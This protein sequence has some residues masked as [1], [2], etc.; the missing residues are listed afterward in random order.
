MTMWEC[1]VVARP[2]GQ[3]A[4]GILL[5]WI[6]I[7]GIGSSPLRGQE[8]A[9][10]ALSRV[11]AATVLVRASGARSQKSGVGFL[12]TVKDKVGAIFTS[13]DV[14]CDELAEGLKLECVFH[15]GTDEEQVVKA[16]LAGM[17][18][19]DEWAVLTVS[20][21]ALP[22][23][24]DRDIEDSPH[25]TDS[26]FVLGFPSEAEPVKRRPAPALI[27]MP[28]TITHLQRDPDG[29]LELVQIEGG[30]HRSNA[31]APVVTASGA[32]VGGLVSKLRITPH[33]S[34]ISAVRLAR[35]LEIGV[36]SVAGNL[37][38]AERS[39]WSFKFRVRTIDPFSDVR[40]FT[41]LT[42]PVPPE[43]A[44]TVPMY[45]PAI[46]F[47][48]GPVLADMREH[49]LLKLPSGEF[50]GTVSWT[51]AAETPEYWVQFRWKLADESVHYSGSTRFKAGHWKFFA[52]ILTPAGLDGNDEIV[53]ESAI[54]FESPLTMAV[55]GGSGRYLVAQSQTPPQVH[56]ID[57]QLR[58]RVKTID[59]TADAL[60]AAGFDGFVVIT[61]SD[62]GAQRWSFA[63]AK[64]SEPKPIRVP[65]RI[66][67]VA[68]GHASRGP[69]LVFSAEGIDARNR[70]Y[71][72]LVDWPNWKAVVMNGPPNR[73]G[74]SAPRMRRADEQL[75]ILAAANGSTFGV[76]S[77]T[78][79]AGRVEMIFPDRG[80]QASN[81]I[82]SFGY[83]APTA[84]GARVCTSRGVF[85]TDLAQ[86]QT[87]LPSLPSTSSD[88]YLSLDDHGL[89]V[90]RVSDGQDVRVLVRNDSLFAEKGIRA[91]LLPMERRFFLVPQVNLLAI[92]SPA[93]NRLI[94]APLPLGGAG[95]SKRPAVAI[96][97]KDRDSVPER[98]KEKGKG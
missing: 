6:A 2:A 56:V 33:L 7:G 4:L 59:V 72:S 81:G 97:P 12:F 54:T 98:P 73:P 22:A 46:G 30:I 24:L 67:A 77:L 25:E 79:P 84:D 85:Q 63:G 48:K 50:A 51:I 43:V 13:H 74:T 31:G 78:S 80:S 65:G 55:L 62:S 29:R 91:G 5:L 96:P 90:R 45:Q 88:Y 1:G 52:D 36:K 17:D 20:S 41:L 89:R 11:R 71:F 66:R 39:E 32:L 9:E 70:G 83:V 64:K 3:I 21:G 82:S 92:I 15:P 95:F 57:L 19:A 23:P 87:K 44:K 38:Q 58:E 42:T 86:G 14:V 76:W 37:D 49:E 8:L 93:S 75:G 27:A 61:P 53:E 40:E 47:S 94:F 18:E 68:M 35:V 16:N 10:P 60:V 26:V 69:M 34:V 28:S